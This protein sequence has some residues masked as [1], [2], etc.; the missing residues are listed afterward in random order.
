[1]GGSVIFLKFVCLYKCRPFYAMNDKALI[2]K[3]LNGNTEYFRRIVEQY[4]ES[5]YAFVCRMVKVP[6]DAEE[7]AEDVFVKAYQHLA[8]FQ[9]KGTTML[10]WLRSI[11][12]HESLNHLRRQSPQ[13]VSLDDDV[14]P[15]IADESMMMAGQ[16]NDD[17]RIELLLQAIEFLPPDDRLLIELFYYDEQPIKDIALIT[18]Q[19]QANI[20][21]R[22]YRIRQRLYKKITKLL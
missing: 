5:I 3:I 1:M 6:E 16:D 18:G 19:S 15:P 2:S 21:T 17:E 13:I 11:A 10:C 22:L 20:L 14:G 4:S 12:Y 8:D 9:G 7:I